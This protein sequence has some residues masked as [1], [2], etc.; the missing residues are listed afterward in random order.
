LELRTSHL[1]VDLSATPSGNVI[2]SRLLQ[3]GDLFIAASHVSP[4]FFELQLECRD[5]PFAQRQLSLQAVA[6]VDEFADTHGTRRGRVAVS[7]TQVGRSF[8][9]RCEVSDRRS[10]LGDT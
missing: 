10:D 2:R 4:C 1:G 6:L 7:D 3:L 5:L 9:R 8:E